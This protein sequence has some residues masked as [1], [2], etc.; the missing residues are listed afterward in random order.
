MFILLPISVLG[1]TLNAVLTRA[2]QIKFPGKARLLTLY[3][4]GFCLTAAIAFLC[5]SLMAREALFLPPLG[6]LLAALFGIF[7]YLAIA[8]SAKGYALG[9]MSL[10]AIIFNMSLFLPLLYSVCFLNEVLTPIRILGIALILITMTLTALGGKG[11]NAEP[12]TLLWFVTVFFAFLSNGLT[13]VIQKGYFG[14][15]ADA[16]TIFFMAIAYGT[17]AL[18]FFLHV[19]LRACLGADKKTA[20]P[21][22]EALVQG[23]G[24]PFPALT[25]FAVTSGLCSFGGNALLSMLCNEID[26]SVLFPC[27]NGGICVLSA[28]SSFLMFKEKVTANK[29]IAIIIGLCAIVLLSL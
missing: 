14:V 27:A 23:S 7:F 3:Q 4:G 17:A 21:S 11:K 28:L 25:L 15:N 29:I 9:S 20:P 10:T 8:L 26:G 16:S 2:F 24:A 12:V 5:T 6:L 13:G 19:S 22:E 18:C 1:F